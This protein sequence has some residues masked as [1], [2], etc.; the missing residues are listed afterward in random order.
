M[1]TLRYTSSGQ[2]LTE[3]AMSH[4]TSLSESVA[5]NLEAHFDNLKDIGSSLATRVQFRELVRQGRWTEAVKILESVP[6]DFPFIERLFLTDPQGTLLA[7]T[8]ELPGVRGNNFA[9]RDWYIGVS[10]RWEPYVSEIYK[11]SA[12]PQYNVVATAVPIRSPNQEII[13]IL[14]LQIRVEQLFAWSKELNLAEGEFT[15]FVDKNGVVAGHPD[16]Q[17]ETNLVNF[18]SVPVVQKVLQGEKGVGVF[19][20]PVDRE[21]RLTAYTPVSDYGWG[22]LVAQPTNLAFADR[23]NRLMD[24]TRDNSLIIIFGIILAVILA[25]TRIGILNL[26]NRQRVFLASVGDGVFAIDR[27]GNV[28]LFNPAATF[29]TGFMESEVIGRPYREILHFA[30]ETGGQIEDEFIREALDGKKSNMSNKILLQRKDGSTIPVGDS[31]API[32]DSSGRVTGAIIVFRDI[33]KERE[34][35]RSKDDFLSIA[36][37]ELRTPLTAIRG[38]ASLIQQYF[39]D[40]L[41]N[42]DL[43]QMVDDTYEA[44]I[45]LIQ[46]VND[47][48]NVGRLEQ[49][50]ME[51]KI[52]PIDLAL[53]IKEVLPELKPSAEAKGLELKFEEPKDSLP[54]ALADVNRFK[55]VFINIVGN[56]IKYTD[57]GSATVTIDQ[58]SDILKVSIKDTGIGISAEAQAMLFKKFQKAGDNKVTHDPSKS[59]GLGLY[60][61]KMMLEGMGGKIWLEYSELGKG[62]TFCLSLPIATAQTVV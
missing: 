19:H 26:A 9:M 39:S 56:A 11:R 37:H 7:D 33:T 55:E 53:T 24:I 36:S 62:S 15:Y 25:H 49:G 50:R 16:H 44:S 42:P 20:N 10:E 47:F 48:L 29:I 28:T 38:N 5:I 14:V 40:Q 34:L 18:S 54:K 45:R 17:D 4:R 1:G 32:L 43:K 46:I 8:P 6:K 59:T 35:E 30:Q 2:L 51:F 31:A 21:E 58:D 27:L 12:V 3:L 22:A 52:E 41:K 60:I 57:Q 13:G 61:S 23:N